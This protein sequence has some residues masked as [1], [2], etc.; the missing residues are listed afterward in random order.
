MVTFGFS[1]ANAGYFLF[2]TWEISPFFKDIVLYH[3]EPEKYDGTNKVLTVVYYANQLVHNIMS[4]IDKV[5]RGEMV[6]A[7]PFH[8]LYNLDTMKPKPDYEKLILGSKE[9]LARIGVPF[10]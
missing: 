3:H 4:E 10:K 6:F 5:E 1:H 8:E 9:D 7:V 2:D